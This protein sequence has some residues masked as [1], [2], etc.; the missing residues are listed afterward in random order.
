VREV[1]EGPGPST[2]DLPAPGCW[3]LDL[4]WADRTDT[5]RL[6]YLPG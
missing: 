6:S 1:A 5:L 3:T 2:L 4:R